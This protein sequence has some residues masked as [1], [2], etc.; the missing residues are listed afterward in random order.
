M[1][2][3]VYVNK[4]AAQLNSG[5]PWAIFCPTESRC[6]F[7]KDVIATTNS[8]TL[9][10][11]KNQLKEY[12]FPNPFIPNFVIRYE[13]K[14]EIDDDNVAYISSEDHPT[15]LVEERG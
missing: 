6:Y 11:C 15:L 3:L 13:G 14:L 9:S 8:R 5:I 2:I 1:E 7:V 4:M 10:F 12:N